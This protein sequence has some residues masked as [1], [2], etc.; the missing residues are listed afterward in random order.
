MYWL[1]CGNKIE[2]E[3]ILVYQRLDFQL[4]IVPFR[5]LTYLQVS[6]LPFRWI[7]KNLSLYHKRQID[8]IRRLIP[9]MKDMQHIMRVLLQSPTEDGC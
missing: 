5:F 2:Y 9:A 6:S 4:G 3:L 8:R 1:S 7:G